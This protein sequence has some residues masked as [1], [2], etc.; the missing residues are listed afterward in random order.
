[1]N[2]L[3]DHAEVERRQIIQQTHPESVEEQ[4]MRRQLEFEIAR[5]ERY[6][7][8]MRRAMR[9][10]TRGAWNRAEAIEILRWGLLG[11]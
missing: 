8:A 11:P 3:H 4:Q 5:R 9:Q 1:M 7:F 10:L 6:E 2:T